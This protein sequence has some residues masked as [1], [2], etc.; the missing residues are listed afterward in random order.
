[1]FVQATSFIF[2]VN[3][4]VKWIIVTWSAVSNAADK[5]RNA[6]AAGHPD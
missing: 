3:R 1:M 2:R 6:S 5:S 4:S